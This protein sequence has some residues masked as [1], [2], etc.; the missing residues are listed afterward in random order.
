[1]TAQNVTNQPFSIGQLIKAELYKQERTV[2][3]L[4]RKI[5][6]DRRNIYNVF[7]RTYVD[8][9]LLLRISVALHTDFFAYYSRFLQSIENQQITPPYGR[10]GVRKRCDS[11]ITMW[12]GVSC[13]STGSSSRS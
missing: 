9:E 4:A 2:T 11:V 5:N 3:W 12:T 7:E 10:A 1:M 6:C 8:T 13:G